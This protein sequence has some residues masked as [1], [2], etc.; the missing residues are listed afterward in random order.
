M[1]TV[2][3]SPRLAIETQQRSLTHR[4]NGLVSRVAS[5]RSNL[6]NL[7][8]DLEGLDQGMNSPYISE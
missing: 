8:A 5:I 6:E 2:G 1:Q 4:M 7:N 3:G